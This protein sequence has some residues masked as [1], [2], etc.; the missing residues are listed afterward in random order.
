MINGYGEYFIKCPDCSIIASV[1]RIQVTI[2]TQHALLE[3]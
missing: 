2:I 1:C 3:F